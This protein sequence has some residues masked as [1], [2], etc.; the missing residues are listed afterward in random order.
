MLRKKVMPL[1][2]S[3][4]RVLSSHFEYLI[5]ALEVDGFK[6]SMDRNSSKLNQG[7]ETL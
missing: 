4:Y 2:I 7:S 5:K 3:E 1:N 6:R